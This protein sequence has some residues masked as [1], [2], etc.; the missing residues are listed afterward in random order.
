[1]R[2]R[3]TAGRDLRPAGKIR[4]WMPH[5]NDQALAAY[6]ALIIDMATLCEYIRAGL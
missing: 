2:A 1:M 6:N 5:G 4:P 3:C